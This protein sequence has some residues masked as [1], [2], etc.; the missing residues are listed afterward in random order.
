MLVHDAFPFASRRVRVADL[1][2]SI[3]R[4]LKEVDPESTEEIQAYNRFAGEHEEPD[5]QEPLLRRHDLARRLPRRGPARP[6]LP[7]IQARRRPEALGCAGLSGGGMR[8]VYLGGIDDRIAC[9]CCVGMMTTWR[10]YLL[11]KCYTHTWMIYIPG[12]P[13]DLDYPE[14][15][16][17]RV[18]KPTLVLNDDEDDLFTIGEMKRADRIMAEVF[19][20]AGAGDRYHCSFY[21]G[22]HKFDRPMQAEAF[23]W[24][25]RWLKA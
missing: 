15:L 20:K 19:A 13:L 8:T 14:I 5:G 7:R 1:A 4:D 16:G 17:L 21:P 24:F 11:H 9:A 12:L 3:R 25:D 2:P 6:G 23:D 18:P 22:E 10:D